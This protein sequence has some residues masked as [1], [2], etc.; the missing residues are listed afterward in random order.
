MDEREPLDD[1][2]RWDGGCGRCWGGCENECLGLAEMEV[3]DDA[4][5]EP[6]ESTKGSA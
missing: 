6:E 5:V 1:C 2:C 3:A 4:V